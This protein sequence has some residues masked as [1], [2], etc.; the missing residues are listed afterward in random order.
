LHRGVEHAE[1][2]DAPGRDVTANVMEPSADTGPD[3]RAQVFLEV[4]KGSIWPVDGVKVSQRQRDRLQLARR[5]DRAARLAPDQF[6]GGNGQVVGLVHNL[7]DVPAVP[8]PKRDDL[9]GVPGSL[10]P[11]LDEH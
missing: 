3:N 8:G 11:G 6:E 9:M 2:L 10:V 7:G 1:P 4:G 5:P